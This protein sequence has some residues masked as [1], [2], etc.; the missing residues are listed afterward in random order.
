MQARM[1]RA[2]VVPGLD[3]LQVALHTI[4]STLSQA[5]ELHTLI[6]HDADL[7]AANS[8]QLVA[9]GAWVRLLEE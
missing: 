1:A 2:P 4:A 7:L 9:A 3:L 6:L 8:D 5:K